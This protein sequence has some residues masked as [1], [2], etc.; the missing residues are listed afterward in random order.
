M[1]GDGPAALQRGE[2]PFSLAPTAPVFATLRWLIGAG[3][4]V[5]TTATSDDPQAVSALYALCVALQSLLSVVKAA[6]TAGLSADEVGF[7]AGERP[8]S[9][10]SAPF[11][12]QLSW[13]ME[14][15]PSAF[16][17]SVS[18]PI[19]ASVSSILR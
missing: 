5:F 1:R 12:T 7:N 6:V 19:Y 8:G 4:S 13:L 11:M 17:A 16:A 14:A 3:A 2:G 18:E 10:A 15:T 9:L